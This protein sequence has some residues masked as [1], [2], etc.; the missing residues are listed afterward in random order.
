[1]LDATAP[2]GRLATTIPDQGHQ[3]G[4]RDQRDVAAAVARRDPRPRHRHRPEQLPRGQ[5]PGRLQH[6]R[7][8]VHD[9]RAGGAA[10][11]GVPAAAPDAR[12]DHP[13][14]DRHQP[15]AARHWRR[16][17]R[18]SSIGRASTSRSRRCRS[19]RSVPTTGACP[20]LDDSADHRAGRHPRERRVPEP[21][22]LGAV[23]GDQR[24]AGRHA[25]RAARDSRR[26]SCCRAGLDRVAGTFD[27][28][29]DDPLRLARLEGIGVQPVVPV[30]QPGADGVLQHGRRHRRSITPQR[31]GEGEFLVEGLKEG[32][33]LF[34]IEIETTLYGL[35]SG[36]VRMSGQAAGAVFVRNPTFS[37]TLAHP[38][39]IRSGEPYD[40]YATVTNTSQT[41]ANLVTVN[42]D[43][44]AISGAQLLS[45][46]AVTFDTIAPGQAATREVPPDR[47][48]DRPG[49]VQ[50][51]HRR[52]GRRRRHPADD[53]HRRARRAAA[54]RTRSCCPRATDRLPASLVAA[55]QR[56]LGPGVQHRDRAGRGAAAGRA[57]RP[58]A[59]GR[60]IAGS[61]SRR[62]ANGSS[63]ASRST[64]VIQDLLLDWLG[65]TTA[66]RRLRSDPA[67]DRRRRR[68]PR[69]DRGDR[70][71]SR[72]PVP[73]VLAYQSGLREH[74]VGR[75]PHVSAAV[76]STAGHR[77]AAAHGHARARRR[78]DGRSPTASSVRSSS[79]AR[80]SNLSQRG[81]RRATGRR[82][83][84][85]SPIAIAFRSWRAAE[86]RLRPRV[87]VPG[88]TPVQ[89]RP[90]PVP[91]SP[92]RRRR[93]RARSKSISRRPRRPS[94]RV[95]RNGDGTS[96]DRRRRDCRHR[97][98]TRRRRRDRAA[99]V[100]AYSRDGR[101][102]RDPATYGLAASL[103][104]ST[105]RSRR[106]PRS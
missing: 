78:R 9:R 6:R 20:T 42:L 102:S 24:R 19:S 59:D 52:G 94:L 50:L 1:M 51:V 18:R 76:G 89:L 4:L 83:R 56:V 72:R 55:A 65:N 26:A 63:S 68:V 77:G 104:S 12:A 17:C 25:A 39:T 88:A 30:V 93:H 13:A 71:D 85:S 33:H 46:P 79:A 22:L 69:R 75:A 66:R 57:L 64:R 87:V 34:D 73:A 53:R 97:R 82:R 90:A 7:H 100:S 43:P 23:D 60:S 11:A 81:G 10:D 16:R 41:A 101:R 14:A 27:Q 103:S 98:R 62:P 3:R 61:I 96:T 21:V 5:L 48:E 95:D 67:H 70:P 47:A 45:D 36:P 105:S 84:A 91:R 40:L 99:A 15:A 2:D 58:A 31:S 92:T 38:R 74:G 54:R 28:P 8:A 80:R 86:R 32:S 35:P 106:R 29:G 44:R 49:D 37:V